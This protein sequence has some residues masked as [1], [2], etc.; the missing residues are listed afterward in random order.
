MEKELSHSIFRNPETGRIPRVGW[1]LHNVGSGGVLRRSNPEVQKYVDKHYGQRCGHIPD[2]EEMGVLVPNLTPEVRRQIEY[3]GGLINR[4]LRV[5][6]IDTFTAGPGTLVAPYIN[7]PELHPEIG[8]AWGID[9]R[10]VDK[11]KN[12]A[13]TTE[14]F[15]DSSYSPFLVPD[16]VIC[17]NGDMVSKSTRLLGEIS[18]NYQKAGMNN[19]YPLGIMIR[20]A[21]CDGGYGNCEVSINSRG[22]IITIPNGEASKAL[23]HDSWEAAL[24]Y[25]N[26]MLKNSMDLSRER[27]IVVSRLIDAADCPGN[28]VL[29]YEGVPHSL[30]WNGNVQM[31]EY[32][33]SSVGTSSYK[34]EREDLVR[35]QERYEQQTAEALAR[36]VRQ[37]AENIGISPDN[38]TGFLSVDIL[39]PGELEREYMRRMDIS[40]GVYFCEVNPRITNWT[41]A[42]I[43][44]ARVDGNSVVST[45][46]LN[47]TI[48]KGVLTIDKHPIRN[49]S[50]PEQIR[51]Q[52]QE[53][54]RQ[55]QNRDGSRVI[56]RMPTK[57]AGIIYIGDVRTGMDMTNHIL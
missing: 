50:G 3:V 39:I 9:P 2:A 6:E 20:A 41:D 25:A 37:K 30:G 19:D 12:K 55:M 31:P 56:L 46:S 7:T 5:Q 21:E 57:P 34:P 4:K 35:Y 10:L 42:L 36:Y 53:V 26:E 52:V 1:G 23:V 49:G 51:E 27:R 11:M 33:V 13:I 18:N 24:Q 45:N 40:G 16:F 29:F 48:R 43:L 54:D 17:E 44:A 22:Q 32:G 28:S 8:K 15:S 47:G 14:D 38:L